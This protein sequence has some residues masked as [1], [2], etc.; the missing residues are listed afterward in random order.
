MSRSGESERLPA[1]ATSAGLTDRLGYLLKQVQAGFSEVHTQA[2]GEL[3]INGRELAVLAVLA[4]PET[5]SQQQA[6]LRLGVDRTTMV[7]LVDSLELKQLVERRPDPLDRRRNLVQLTA[8]GRR[9]L[10]D[11]NR[12]SRQAEDRFLAGLDPAEAKFFRTTLQRLLAKPA[13]GPDRS[14]PQHELNH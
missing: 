1:A 9:V 13:A 12:A 14:G 5:P 2:L 4:G 10:Q 3:R 11:G 8:E 7:D 6:A